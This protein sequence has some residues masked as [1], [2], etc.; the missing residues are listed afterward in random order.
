[1]LGVAERQVTATT[2]GTVGV[3]WTVL[4]V[5]VFLARGHARLGRIA[6]PALAGAGVTLILAPPLSI[7][8]VVEVCARMVRAA[9][10]S[11]SFALLL[12]LFAAGYT[13]GPL[14]VGGL[15]FRCV[16]RDH[17]IA[18]GAMLSIFYA[19]LIAPA[20][21][22]ECLG[23]PLEITAAWMAGAVLGAAAA[24]PVSLWLGGVRAR[25]A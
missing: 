24:G 14:L 5:G 15:G 25:V 6:R 3:V 22:L 18:D 11:V 12:V 4:F 8:S 17:R 7:P 16:E 21:Y 13:A 2:I 23:L 9:P 19:L 20:V 10:E 1:V